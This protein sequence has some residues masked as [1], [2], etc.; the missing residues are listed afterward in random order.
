V[1]RG[2][3]LRTTLAALCLAGAS[4]AVAGLVPSAAGAAVTSSPPLPAGTTSH[5]LVDPHVYP[6]GG[7]FAFGQT[8]PA[9]TLP[10][11]LNAVIV[12]A[13]PTRDGKGMWLVG[14]DGGV[15]N[16]GD[17]PF[18]G[19]LGALRLQGPVIAMAGTADNQGYWLAALDG[20]VF[21]L[22]DARFYG[23]MGG[24]PLNQP[25]VGMAATPDGKGYWL[26]ASDGGI[27]AFGDAAF[28]GSMGG[29]PLNAGIADMAATPDGKGYWLV[30]SDGGV[31]TFG[32]AAFHGSL[33]TSAA[34][35]PV[36]TIVPTEGGQGYWLVDP[37]GWQYSFSNPPPDGSFAGSAA[38]VAAAAS[39]VQPDP[40]TGNFCNP[41]GPCEE[42]C[43]LF[44]T[45]AV[46]QAGIPIPS[47]PFTGSVWSW[48]AQRGL[49]LPPTAMPVPGD[50]VLFGTG[51]WSTATSVHM[52]VVAQVWPDGAIVTIEGDAGPGASG[53]LAVVINGP[54]LVGDSLTYNGAGVYA[55]VQP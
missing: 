44:A 28:Y 7:L 23:S 15:Y 45:W 12:A 8:S 52:G 41:Y 2:L 48:G 16:S 42:W 46:Q 36:S 32:D 4:A 33:G 47:Y 40:D 14:A 10:A 18:E 43:A 53:R 27:F 25:I 49:A 50:L 19:S 13:A 55:F 54:F 5:A 34:A 11:T 29:E 38:I 20:G 21:A 3:L 6:G 35:T 37:D 51:P 22:G 9:P 24:S 30:G 17:A 26:V 31:F 39:Q 1:A